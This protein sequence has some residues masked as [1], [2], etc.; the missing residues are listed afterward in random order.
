MDIMETHNKIIEIA[1][2]MRPDLNRPVFTEKT[3]WQWIDLL[4]CAIITKDRENRDLKMFLDM[5]SKIDNAKQI[6][7][8]TYTINEEWDIVPHYT[9]KGKKI[10]YTT[11]PYYNDNMV[12]CNNK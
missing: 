10:T 12:L 5:T 8:T 3:R 4:R 7:K 9:K 11:D 1:N 6:G 2:A